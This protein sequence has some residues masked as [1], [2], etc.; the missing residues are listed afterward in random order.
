MKSPKV[1]DY[2]GISGRLRV[3]KDVDTLLER[4]ERVRKAEKT[5]WEKEIKRQQE[6]EMA[7]CTFKP[8]VKGGAPDF[9]R[10]MAA[11]RRAARALLAEKENPPPP[12][13]PEWQ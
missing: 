4:I 11:T 13:R 9:V 1:R 8:E 3:L 6:Q 2:N 7:Q 12:Q 5:R 10:R